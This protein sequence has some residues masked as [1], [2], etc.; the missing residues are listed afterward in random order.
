MRTDFS[1][2]R[3]NEI[4]FFVFGRF[5]LEIFK[6]QENWIETEKSPFLKTKLSAKIND[7]ISCQL[8]R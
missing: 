1:D 6:I 3:I 8:G 2:G 5:F 7:R 4:R